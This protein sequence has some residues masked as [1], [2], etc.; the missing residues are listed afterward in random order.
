MLS[1]NAQD[2]EEKH[3]AR[4]Y[5]ERVAAKQ[6]EWLSM[7]IHIVNINSAT[8]CL[9]CGKETIP[10]SDVRMA[11]RIDLPRNGLADVYIQTAVTC[12]CASNILKLV[13]SCTAL[14]QHCFD[15]PS[16]ET[17]PLAMDPQSLP[18]LIKHHVQLLLELCKSVLL[19][20]FNTVYQ[21]I[22]QGPIAYQMA[23]GAMTD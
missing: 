10:L 15:I 8:N 5:C 13:I 23:I 19:S 22:S 21:V 3:L 20:E 7:R 9:V 4:V 16:H 14:Y 2:H 17:Q 1:G 12:S 11:S 6:P 18:W